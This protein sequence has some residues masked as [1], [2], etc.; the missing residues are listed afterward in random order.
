MKKYALGTLTIKDQE[1][2]DTKEEII[3]DLINQM[4]KYVAESKK[5]YDDSRMSLEDKLSAIESRCG[6]FC[7][8]ADFLN[9]TMRVDARTDDNTLYTQQMFNSFHYWK[10]MLS[11][12][13][14]K[15]SKEGNQND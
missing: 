5:I 9:N 14:S 2:Q 7:G 12:E 4:Q 13:I 8:L 3:V 10:Q 6:R 1:I 11:I 15:A